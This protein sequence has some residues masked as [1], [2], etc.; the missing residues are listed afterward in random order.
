MP[1]KNHCKHLASDNED[2]YARQLELA[3]IRSDIALLRYGYLVEKSKLWPK[4][5]I[6]FTPTNK[7]PIN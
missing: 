7:K 3:K 1:K 5:E 6:F 4:T 2:F